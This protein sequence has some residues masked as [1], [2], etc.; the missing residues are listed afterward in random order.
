MQTLTFFPNDL[1]DGWEIIFAKAQ[2]PQL[3]VVP[4]NFSTD[5]LKALDEGLKL[6]DEPWLIGL[7]WLY[8]K[9]WNRKYRIPC[10]PKLAK[11]VEPIGDYMWAIVK[12]ASD[13]HTLGHPLTKQWDNAG[14]WTGAIFE[15]IRFDDTNKGMRRMLNE[16][17]V[18]T[19]V[20]N[21]RDFIKVLRNEDTPNIQL[22][23]PAYWTLIDL[24]MRYIRSKKYQNLRDKNL[25]YS[26]SHHI[27]T[28]KGLVGSLARYAA[29]LDSPHAQALKIKNN[30]LFVGRKG[31]DV[32][33][34]AS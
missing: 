20:E 9:E 26:K 6:S 3:I 31:G 8:K 21:I 11:I 32:R 28:C 13:V 10:S 14:Q 24:T 4:P 12:L 16:E 25:T 34:K 27:Y 18:H 1:G 2:S 29:L 17:G 19:E 7:H 23:Q 22:E 30:S 5:R 33:I 15:E